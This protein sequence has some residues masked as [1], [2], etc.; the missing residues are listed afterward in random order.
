[1]F[2]QVSANVEFTCAVS[3][4]GQGVCWGQGADGQL[5]NGTTSRRTLPTPVSGGLVFADLSGGA[6]YSCGVTT[7]ARAYCWGNNFWGNLG[8]GTQTTRLKPTPVAGTQ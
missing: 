6:A 1:V 5:G 7:T 2:E 4:S 3:R 8:D